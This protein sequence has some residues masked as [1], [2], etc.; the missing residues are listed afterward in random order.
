MKT[1]GSLTKSEQRTQD[2][3]LQRLA[4][5]G[6]PLA[7]QKHVEAPWLRIE[8]VG[9]PYDNVCLAPP[10]GGYVAATWLRI[11]AMKAGVRIC[12]CE[13]TPKRWSDDR[14]YL[15]DPP[16]RLPI[17]RDIANLDYPTCDV[18][19]HRISAECALAWGEII[20]G[21]LI[22]Q[23]LVR[24]PD[25]FSTGFMVEFKLCFFDQFDNGYPITV[26]LRVI[27][28]STPVVRGQQQSTFRTVE[29][30]RSPIGG[31][32]PWDDRKQGT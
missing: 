31:S 17:Y 10:I 30:Q 27:R 21:V 6:V 14:I 18:L 20:E 7:E 32:R 25:W 23:S 19:N 24:P 26:A 16:D 22:A 12:H 8:Q 13:I 5:A 11:L 9:G 15:L 3:N 1:K 4:A 2:L 28:D 29:G